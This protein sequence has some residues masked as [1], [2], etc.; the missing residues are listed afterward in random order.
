MATVQFEIFPYEIIRQAKNGFDAFRLLEDEKHQVS[1]K[2][3]G[4]TAEAAPTITKHSPVAGEERL[5]VTGGFYQYMEKFPTHGCLAWIMNR[6]GQVLHTWETDPVALFANTEGFT[7]ELSPDN[8][9]PVGMK[10]GAD[11]NLTVSF[12]GRNIFPYTIGV[13]QFAPDGKLLWKKWDY[14]HHW[15]DVDKDGQI[16]APS[17]RQIS[18]NGNFEGTYIGANC[19]TGAIKEEGIHIYN[20]DGSVSRDLWIFDS[21]IKSN[22][23][24]FIY[25][26]PS[27]CDPAHINSVEV[28]TET[29]AELIA[30][31]EVGDLLVSVREPSVVAILDGQNGEVKY[32]TAGRTAAQHGPQFLPDGS[33]VIFDNRGGNPALGGTRIMHIDMQTGAANVAFPQREEGPAMPFSSHDGGHVAVS[34]DGQRV[35]VSSKQQSRVFEF[36]L[37]TGEVLWEMAH[38]MSMKP[39]LQKLDREAEADNACFRT[40]G[41][42]Y[43]DNVPFLKTTTQ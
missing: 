39:Y 33:V 1:I 27:G 26:H 32:A 6:D 25:S 40:Y 28:V 3:W 17:Q 20:P 19:P 14:S 7:G 30:G 8:V 4:G 18:V 29:I 24:G 9:Y 10:L 21:F 5:L 43:L 16:Y 13:A 37:E 36:E 2:T 31:V 42:Y 41:T 34:P 38:C 23:P 12:H 15:I 22:W 11:G 35:M